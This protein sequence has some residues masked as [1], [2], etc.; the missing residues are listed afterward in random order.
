MEFDEGGWI[1]VEEQLR[2]ARRQAEE[3]MQQLADGQVRF[4]Y[5]VVLNLSMRGM[6]A[7]CPIVLMELIADEQR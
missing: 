5:F 4:T 2:R 6:N 7:S 1:V 3:L